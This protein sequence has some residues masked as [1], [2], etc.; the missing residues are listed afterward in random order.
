[1]RTFPDLAALSPAHVEA[2]KNKDYLWDWNRERNVVDH[3]KNLP[4]EEIR[5]RLQESSFPYAVC[6]EN[7]LHDFNIGTC[8]RNANAFNAREV[9]Y[10]GEKH[11]DRRSS[12][13]V[14]AYTNIQFL[15]TM[16]EF[17]R[18][19]ER[20]VIIGVDNI[21]GSVA[22]DDFEYPDNSLFVFGGE[23]PGLT[24]AM[25]ELTDHMI[26]LNQFGSVRSLNAGTASGIVMNDFVTKF[27]RKNRNR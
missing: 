22:I 6:V 12:V 14:Q 5:A 3:F 19:K 27:R 11:F 18:L 1:M 16:E 8:I 26:M 25:I 20:Y 7:W 21:P 15:R 17:L 10:L 24:P 23:G 4:D 13:G 9:F 2:S